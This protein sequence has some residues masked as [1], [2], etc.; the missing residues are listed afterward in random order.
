V[1]A[2]RELIEALSS[3]QV[4]TSARQPSGFQLE[5]LLPPRS[6]LI[7]VLLVGSVVLRVVLF[8][9]LRGL[10]IVLIDGFV[11]DAEVTP[12]AG[13]AAS[14]LRLTGS[15]LTTVMGL[16]EFDGLP[17]LGTPAPARIP[18]ILSKYAALGVVPVVVPV[19]FDF[20]ETPL[21]N[22]ERQKGSDLAYVQQL[23]KDV[24]YVFYVEPSPVPA[25]S[26]A[27]WGPEIKTG[28]PQPALNLDMDT[29]SNVESLSFRLDTEKPTQY[30]L[31]VQEP[32][33]KVTLP[34]PV[35]NVSLLNPPL[36]AIPPATKKFEFLDT[37]KLDPIRVALLGLGKQAET[38]ENVTANG[39]LDVQRYG[40]VL[41]ARRLV[42]VRGAGTAFDGLYYVQ[43]VT[44]N[45][46][47][48]EYKQS[49]TLSRSGLVST[50]PAVPV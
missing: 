12:G 47:R 28:V 40:N 18:L 23:A 17:F 26:I 20:V 19:P 7:P 38:F 16:F 37:K 10:P 8:V 24:G 6:P 3:V 39:S 27:Y 21:E 49:F 35:P 1:P 11:T 4:T 46:K 13:G 42:G 22:F 34:V 48:G 15:D 25:T 5:F 44:H 50:V 2:P 9:T 31:W 43:S 14:A 33:T 32:L 36:G 29:H 45:I 41:Q 30:L